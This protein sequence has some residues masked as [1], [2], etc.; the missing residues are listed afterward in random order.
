MI[1][2]SG[3]G[4]CSPRGSSLTVADAGISVIVV[5]RELHILV[6]VSLT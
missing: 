3:S 5:Q 6:K 4:L 2:R 1:R